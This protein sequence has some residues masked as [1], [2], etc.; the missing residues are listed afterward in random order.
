MS[1]Y[2][3]LMGVQILSGIG[4]IF[5]DGKRCEANRRDLEKAEAVH[6]GGTKDVK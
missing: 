2:F 3:S 1:L 5:L 6:R 4:K